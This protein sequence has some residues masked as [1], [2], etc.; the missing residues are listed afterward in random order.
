MKA[1][2]SIIISVFNEAETL[3]VLIE[4]LKA[5]ECPDIVY[6]YLFIDDGS[7]DDSYPI[8]E[9]EM[10]RHTDIKVIRFTRN[11]GH[12]MAMTAGL[13]FA[14][15]DAA[16]FMDADLQ[17]PPELIPDFIRHWQQGARIV[18]AKRL[19]TQR[20]SGLSR[21]LRR[22][23]YRLLNLLTD[24]E[25]APDYPDFRLL[26]RHY[27][28]ILL[29]FKEQFRM[30]RGFVYWIGSTRDTVIIPFTAPERFAGASKYSIRNLINLGM[31]AIY[32]FSLKPMK[33]ALIFSG[34]GILFSVWLFLYHFIPY[35]IHGIQVPGYLTIIFT[36]VIMGS[37]QL[38]ILAIFAEYIG[39]IHMQLKNRPLYVIQNMEN[40]N[41][42]ED[43]H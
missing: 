28:N 13:D 32:A 41:E 30:F 18:L 3:P 6:E 35:L 36:V 1:K 2:I 15:G 31:D 33:L 22:F 26:D 24:F 23:Y 27:L 25:I 37:I 40:F 14:S 34:I 21:L 38:F 39:R 19:T 12:E 5:V 43:T 16:I 8:L 20:Q 17:H 42:D 11:F 9:S 4:K 7:T 10:Q 29:K